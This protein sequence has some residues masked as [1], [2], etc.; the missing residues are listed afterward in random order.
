MGLRFI[1]GGRRAVVS[2]A[3]LAA[4]FGC[5]GTATALA[6]NAD[7]AVGAAVVD[8]N[9]AI[10]YKS[11]SSAGT[12][13]V[14]ES[15]GVILTNNHVIRGATGIRVT[16][17]GNGR[18][19]AATVVGYDVSQDIAVLKLRG[20]SGLKTIKAGSSLGI[21]V[22][23]AVTAIGNARGGGSTPSAVRG[24]VTALGRSI[25]AHN[26]DGSP[27]PLKDM[28]ETNAVTEDGDSGGP[29]VDSAG[30]VV[31]INTA[32]TQ[33]TR[34]AYAIPITRALAIAHQIET[35]HPTATNHIG[36]TPL[37][38]LDV[39]TSQSY[40]APR[41][42]VIVNLVL[43]GSPAQR[44]GLVAGDLVTE[45]AGEKVSSLAVLTSSLLHSS[46]NDSVPVSWIDQSGRHR[47]A[48]V[49]LGSGPPQ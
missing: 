49:R 5:G 33:R 11:E 36:P 46:P 20:A 3:F 10:G 37:L 25:T 45:V 44:A 19:Y 1:G 16:D 39:A 32:A 2:A 42:G 30:R 4:L 29:L 26:A 47:H 13:I 22:G 7:S 43:P 38:G 9:A 12:G 6:W 31:G 35:G 8:V 21:K 27:E 15:S 17:L 23:Q 48:N 24:R 18:S 14:L 41:A 40:G 28:I 34:V